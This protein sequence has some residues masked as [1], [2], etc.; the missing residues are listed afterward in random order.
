VSSKK[1]LIVDDEPYIREVSKIS[2]E[3]TMK[4]WDI[5]SAESGPIALILA[6][7][8]HPD[9]ILLDVMMPGMDG[10]STFRQLQKSPQTKAIPVIFLTAK[11]Q[12]E[13]CEQHRLQGAKAT[14][15]K[16][17]NPVTLGLKISQ[18]LGW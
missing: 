2:L 16:P 18:I 1:I 8:E 4:D 17:F 12:P 13:E 10:I 3:S 11:V 5:V 7:S 14:I 6:E 15:A 9:V